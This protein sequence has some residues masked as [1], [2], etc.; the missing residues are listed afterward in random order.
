MSSAFATRTITGA[1]NTT[2]VAFG[3]NAQ[4]GA[5][6]TTRA[7]GT[8][9]RCRA[10]RRGTPA[11]MRSKMPVLP[12]VCA[13]IMPPASSSSGPDAESM[14]AITSARSRMPAASNTLTPSNAATAMST[15][16]NAIAR[17]TAA[18]TARVSAIW[19]SV[20][21]RAPA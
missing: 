6:S 12:S 17:I 13:T 11:L 19:N 8:V 10:W 5:T 1:I 2:V 14:L 18:N 3:S 7:A 9:C 21:A 15:M 4:S 16:S 20:I